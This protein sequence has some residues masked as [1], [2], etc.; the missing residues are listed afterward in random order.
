MERHQTAL[1]VTNEIW[2]DSGK[3]KPFYSDLRQQTLQQMRK[4][5]AL[6]FMIWEVGGK[7]LQRFNYSML[8]YNLHGFHI[9]IH[10]LPHH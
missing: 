7:C 4:M 1:R 5:K 8:F 3:E 6:T 9:S 2:N 10:S